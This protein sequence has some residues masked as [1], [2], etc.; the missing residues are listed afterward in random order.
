MYLKHCHK[1]RCTLRSRYTYLET[2]LIFA[3]VLVDDAKTEVDLVGLL[4]VLKSD[5]W[6]LIPRQDLLGSI[7]RTLENASSACSNDPYRS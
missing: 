6:P 7:L 4:K 5:T 2:G 3:L 1:R